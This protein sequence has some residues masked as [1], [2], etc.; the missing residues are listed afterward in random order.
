L[1]GS[2]RPFQSILFGAGSEAIASNM[3]GDPSKAE[4]VLEHH[5]LFGIY[6]R[7]LEESRAKLLADSLR[8]ASESRAVPRI[9]VIQNAGTRVTGTHRRSCPNCMELDISDQG[10]PSWWV[11]HYLPYFDH[12]PYHGS[13]LIEEELTVAHASRLPTG[14][15]SNRDT[16]MGQDSSGYK[17]YLDHWAS[18][19]RNECPQ[20]QDTEWTRVITDFTQKFGSSSAAVSAVSSALRDLWGLDPEKLS[21]LISPNITRDFVSRQLKLQSSYFITPE[22]IVLLGALED[23]GALCTTEPQQKFRF[24]KHDEA[25][26]DLVDS[27]T[28]MACSSGLPGRFVP[29]LLQQGST[30]AIGDVCR[31][32]RHHVSRFINELSD[33]MLVQILRSFPPRGPSCLIRELLRRKTYTSRRNLFKALNSMITQDKKD[34]QSHKEFKSSLSTGSTF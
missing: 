4:Y 19:M 17:T 21:Q 33:V 30:K 10:F 7:H 16:R 20:I 31:I 29:L 27:L 1:R 26:N 15:G 28:N 25:K 3:F 23:L 9:V 8:F 14:K 24:H 22:R 11:L 2:T 12:C 6:T 18:A 13:K 32:P 5:T 34:A